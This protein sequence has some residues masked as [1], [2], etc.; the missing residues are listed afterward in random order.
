MPTRWRWPPES[1]S[2]RWVAKLAQADRVE[3]LE[4][5][6]DVG[7]RKPAQT[8]APDR[9]VAEPAAQHV[10]DHREPLDQI[11]LLEHH[12]DA[13]ARRAQRAAVQPREV[14]AH[15]Q[16]L[17]RGRVDQAVDAADQ[18]RLAGAG[19]ADDRR[20]AAPLDR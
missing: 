8:R 6:I 14:L 12:A 2:A 19:R 10:L 20:H 15:E 7:G 13:P 16:D 1:W 17:A 11:V 4:G 5:A 18:R 3:E 9:D